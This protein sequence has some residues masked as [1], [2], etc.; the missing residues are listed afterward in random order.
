MELADPDLDGPDHVGEL[1]ETL[2]LSLFIRYI[3]TIRVNM[4]YTY[5]TDSINAVP[6]SL[7]V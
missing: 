1:G 4:F 7:L 3:H 5:I 2:I 6:T